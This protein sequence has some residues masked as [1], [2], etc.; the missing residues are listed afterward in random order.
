MTIF[1]LCWLIIAALTFNYHTLKQLAS[2]FEYR[3]SKLHT[4]LRSAY[5]T[6][7]IW[8]SYVSYAPPA[9]YILGLI[10]DGQARR[11]TAGMFVAYS[12]LTLQDVCVE[13]AVLLCIS[14]ILLLIATAR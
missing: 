10:F 8:V 3:Y 4:A 9:N 2:N 12:E 5:D 14:S 1:F 11:P 13:D 6:N 7:A